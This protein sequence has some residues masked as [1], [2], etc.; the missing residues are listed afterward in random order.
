MGDEERGM[1]VQAQAEGDEEKAEKAKEP[2][3]VAVDVNSELMDRC[4]YIRSYIR[5]TMKAWEK[6][7]AERPEEDKKKATTKVEIAQHRQ[8]R[9][10]IRPLQK[11]LRMYRLEEF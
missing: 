7:L 2:E 5:K 1:K 10:D 11:R 3:E 9:R 6:D 4:D 8:A